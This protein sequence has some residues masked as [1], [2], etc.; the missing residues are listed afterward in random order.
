MS[1]FVSKNQVFLISCRADVA[2][3][4]FQVFQNFATVQR[5]KGISDL[6]KSLI[7][8][9]VYDAIDNVMSELF[10]AEASRNGWSAITIISP[11]LD[12]DIQD[13]LKT[14]SSFNFVT[15]LLLDKI[16]IIKFFS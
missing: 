16:S 13:K 12:V 3:F 8:I 1:S 9:V 5:I 4:C 11:C 10:I 14:V 2:L 7:G 6:P 15:L